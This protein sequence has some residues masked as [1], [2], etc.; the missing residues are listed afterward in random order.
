MCPVPLYSR[1]KKTTCPVPLYSR[2]RRTTCPV[3]LCSREKQTCPVPLYIRGKTDDLPCSSLQQGKADVPC[4]SSQLG[5]TDDSL[6]L[7]TAGK[8]RPPVLFLFTAEKKSQTACSVPL[9][10]KG[11][12]DHLPTCPV[13]L[14]SREKQACPV[15]FT[16]KNRLPSLFLFTEGKNRRHAL[17]LFTAGK[18]QTM[19][20]EAVSILSLTKVRVRDFFVPLCPPLTETAVCERQCRF[21][22]M[23]GSNDFLYTT[24]RLVAFSLAYADMSIAS[25]LIYLTC[26]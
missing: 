22:E 25:K 15:P 13:S 16:G 10:S 11:K 18:K 4:S 3:P 20:T 5:K 6:F 14:Y 12:T 26:P 17:F 7:F 8:N 19:W 24:G 21:L 23:S 1:E 2:K 9:R